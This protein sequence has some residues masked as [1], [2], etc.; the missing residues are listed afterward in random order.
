MRILCLVCLL[1]AVPVTE[2]RKNQDDRPVYERR[3]LR[4]F[5]NGGLNKQDH[6][7]DFR[8]ITRTIAPSSAPI[9]ATMEPTRRPTKAPTSTTTHFPTLIPTIHPTDT[10]TSQPTSG[11]P[12]NVLCEHVEFPPLGQSGTTIYGRMGY[13][14]VPTTCDC[15]PFCGYPGSIGVDSLSPR[16]YEVVGP[17]RNPSSAPTC[18]T[19]MPDYGTCVLGARFAQV[20]IGAFSEFDP[21]DIGANFLGY[22]ADPE[23]YTEFGFPLQGNEEFYLVIQQIRTIEDVENGEGCV[24]S[25]SLQIGDGNTCLT[26]SPTAR[27]TV[28]PTMAPTGKDNT[29]APTLSPLPLCQSQDFPP[30]GSSDTT[31]GERIVGDSFGL[32]LNPTSCSQ[33]GTDRFPETYT[34]GGA[35][36][37]FE[38]VGPFRNPNAQPSCFKVT[39]DIGT[40]NLNGRSLVLVAT[41]TQFNSKAISRNYLG[42]FNDPNQIEDFWFQAQGDEA[43]Y[44]IAQQ[45]AAT[46]DDNSGEGCVLSVVVEVE[47]DGGRCG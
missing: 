4:N 28:S 42:G 39:T 29:A 3:R 37:F 46:T 35:L 2:T 20:I 12:T 6:L 31:I 5:R 14:F 10:P 22:I 21:I 38:Q 33:Y 44:V 47:E 13:G 24:M 9:M 17:F 41:Y 16:L 15:E 40:C 34:Y 36:F 45:I 1:V 8:D 19:V 25:A 18:V 26:Q 32:P 11:H 43:F 7:K 30:L 27:P 23:D